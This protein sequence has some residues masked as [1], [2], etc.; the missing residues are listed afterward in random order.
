MRILADRVIANFG[1]SVPR[2][3]V[4]MSL[5]RT[6]ILR[7]L[8]HAMGPKSRLMLF[9]LERRETVLQHFVGAYAYTEPS[10]YAEAAVRATRPEKSFGA[11]A[12]RNG[13]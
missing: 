9:E 4:S 6:L 3:I 10:A 5:S 12:V 8:A 7:S 13:Q 11:S 2:R 1:E